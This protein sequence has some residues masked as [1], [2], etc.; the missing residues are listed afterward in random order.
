VV[1]L[2]GS[3]R[4][5]ILSPLPAQ[6]QR[7]AREWRRELLSLGVAHDAVDSPEF[8]TAFEALLLRP[9]DDGTTSEELAVSSATI[10]EPPPAD[11]FRED[12]STTNASSIAFLLE[13]CGT[14]ALFLG[15]ALP[16]VVSGQLALLP[17]PSRPLALDVVKVSHHGSKRNTSP[18]LLETM[19]VGHFLLSTDGLKHGHPDIETLLW[20]VDRQRGTTLHFN[21]SSASA[22]AIDHDDIRRRYGHSV[23]VAPPSQ[24]STLVLPAAVQA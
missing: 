1:E 3:V 11:S 22:I 8:E 7:L 6:L 5:T 19:S 16:S 15:D 18:A 21:Y 12:T 2:D 10:S 14:T 20:I 13:Y 23:L 24:L 4:I 17:H 9:F